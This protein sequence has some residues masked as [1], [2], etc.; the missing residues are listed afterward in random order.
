MKNIKMP[1]G[2]QCILLM[3]FATLGMTKTYA[4]I[5]PASYSDTATVPSNPL[6]YL[7]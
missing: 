4:Q 2:L 3:L 7:N 6:T 1:T 5:I